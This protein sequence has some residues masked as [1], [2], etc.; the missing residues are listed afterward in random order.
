ML[1]KLSAWK[2]KEIPGSSAGTYC[3][4]G[5]T[6]SFRRSA[7]AEYIFDRI[8]VSPSTFEPMESGLGLTRLRAYAHQVPHYYLQSFGPAVTHPDTNEYAG[9]LR[10]TIRVSDHLALSMGAR[11]D[12]QTFTTKG[13]QVIR[14]GPMPARFP[15]IPTTS[16]PGFAWLT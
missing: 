9:F 5:S 4:P 6:T 1:R 12:L 15:S 8:K 13:L 16:L 10:D 2:A 7:V 11:Y 14:C 3:S